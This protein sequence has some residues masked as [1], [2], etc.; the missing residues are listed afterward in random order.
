MPPIRAFVATLASLCAALAVAPSIAAAVQDPAP[1]ATAVLRAEWPSGTSQG[2]TYTFDGT[3]ASFAPLRL[4]RDDAAVAPRVA[5]SDADALIELVLW[6]GDRVLG[7]FVAGD[8]DSIAVAIGT[9]SQV[10]VP[11]DALRHAVHPSRRAIAGAEDLVAPERGDR[12]YRRAGSGVDVVDGTLDGLTAEGIAFESRLGR[13]VHAWSEVVALFVEVIDPPESTSG[14]P[15]SVAVD[16]VGGSRLSGR[17]ERIDASGVAIALPWGASLALAAADVALVGADDGRI[18]YL[19]DLAPAAIRGGSA[20][21]DELGLVFAPAIDR[22]VHGA[23][24]V[25]GGRTWPRG[26]GV[27]A[28][29]AI[30]HDLEPGRHARLRG[31]VGIDDST[32]QLAARGAAEFVVR[33]DGQELW[34]SGV[35]RGGDAPVALPTIDVSK[36]ARLELAVEMGPDLNLGDRADW[37]DLVLER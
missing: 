26:I 6:N 32:A 9:T 37:L 23:A 16:L 12:L 20:F 2:A 31:F 29:T 3:G 15:L 18:T 19:S 24:L 30:V 17:L 13:R 21:D 22:A 5:P 33:G 35:L 4:V 28:P 27:Q 11:I 7:R 14:T 25:C 36:F 34:R 10:A 8:D 1:V